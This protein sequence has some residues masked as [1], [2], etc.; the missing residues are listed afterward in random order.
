M[1]DLDC[2]VE[3]RKEADPGERWVKNLITVLLIKWKILN[4][5]EHDET[6]TGWHQKRLKKHTIRR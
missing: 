1:L 6:V 3:E 2:Q 5:I 4:M